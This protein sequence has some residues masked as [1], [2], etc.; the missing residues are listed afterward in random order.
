[1]LKNGAVASSAKAKSL[2][3]YNR[4]NEI[5]GGENTVI[6]QKQIILNEGLSLKD[7]S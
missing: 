1:M 3:N 2:D 6:V 4:I 7:L 5:A